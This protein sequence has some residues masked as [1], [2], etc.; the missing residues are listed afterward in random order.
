ML[1]GGVLAGAAL[2]A[3]GSSS[4]TS[5]TTSTTTTTAPKTAT[6]HSRPDLKP[7]LV[8]VTRGRVGTPEPGYICVTPSGPLLLDDAGDPVWIEMVPQ[9]STNL[10]VQ[11]F[12]GEP[13][14]TWWQGE[15]SSYGVGLSGEFVIAD[16]SYHQLMTVQARNGVPADLH[17]FIIAEDGVAYFFA[18]KPYTTDLSAFGGPT[19]GQA[20]DSTIQG[21]DLNT[22]ALVFDWSTVGHIDLAETH[23]TYSAKQPFDPVHFNAIDV[24]PGGDLL[25][26]AR[27]TWTVYRID[28]ATGN[29]VWRLG[30]KKS[31]FV[32]GPDVEF[33]FQHDARSHPDGTISLFDNQGD[34][35]HA[36]Q[37]RGLVLEVD[38][39]AKKATMKT[40]YLHPD[41][42]LLAGSQGSLQ[43]LPGGHVL[44][45]WGAEP[46][47]TELTGGGRKVLD[48][49]YASGG[50]YRALRFDWKGT[51]TDTPAVA[52]ERSETGRHTVYVS[53]NGSTE[54]ASWRLLAGPAADSLRPATRVRRDGFETAMAA[55]RGATHAAVVALDAAGTKLSQSPT[56]SL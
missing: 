40:A 53:W 27:N 29:I 6:Y 22:G 28:R 18:Y 50:S 21:V 30:G 37:S 16:A 15:I 39:A 56:I 51:P 49:R 32:L 5:T 24:L 43:L 4:S 25:V 8:D 42:P 20:L 10:R 7:A 31:D 2:A 3:C 14:L 45:G 44:I 1:G 17:E 35:P 19:S 13:V 33:A 9:A 12:R 26:S 36:K 52:A 55:P 11:K 23:A 38:E 54:T 46:Y 47:F 41:T 48:G 34:P